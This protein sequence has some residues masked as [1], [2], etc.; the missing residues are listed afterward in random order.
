MG[1]T[2]SVRFNATANRL[3]CKENSTSLVVYELYRLSEK[4]ELKAPGFSSE[5]PDLDTACFARRSVNRDDDLVAAKSD[6]GLV[7]WSVP[8][9]PFG[10]MI[11]IAK[12]LLLIP[13]GQSC[14]LFHHFRYN[15]KIGALVSSGVYID[16]RSKRSGMI[17]F[18]SRFA[19]PGSVE[20]LTNINMTPCDSSNESSNHD[21]QSS[22]D[23]E[24]E[25]DST[26]DDS[27]QNSLTEQDE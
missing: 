25:E 24:D 3:L 2:S 7:V 8:R 17:S 11:E 18:L 9:S 14:N 16:G 26:E 15:E 10:E 19:L 1:I 23:D 13:G 20:T 12:P 6:K 22:L 4:V 27:N 21:S 5:R